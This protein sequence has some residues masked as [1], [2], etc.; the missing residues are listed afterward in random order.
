MTFLKFLCWSGDCCGPRFT[1][2]YWARIGML[3]LCSALH[4]RQLLASPWCTCSEWRKPLV[5]LN[6]AGH[7]RSR[8]VVDVSDCAG[9]FACTLQVAT[10][11]K[12]S[13]C[14]CSC[15]F[16]SLI[17]IYECICL[18]QMT[19]VPCRVLGREVWMSFATRFCGMVSAAERL[20]VCGDGRGKGT[21]V[22]LGC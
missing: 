14:T 17:Y 3:I 16:I 12:W 10:C 5:V 4:Y 9:I 15:C 18:H 6:C 11:F 13:S 20:R 2:V 7:A 19:Y 1:V 8:R 22:A 21:R